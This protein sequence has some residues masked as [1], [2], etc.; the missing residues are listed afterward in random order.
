MRRRWQVARW[1]G[2]GAP[3]S[4]GRTLAATVV[5]AVSLVAC[6]ALAT[7]QQ[8]LTVGTL[9]A[10][11]G[12]SSSI[13][14][15]V[16]LFGSFGQPFAGYSQGPSVVW[17]GFAYAAFPP[18]PGI[19]R[20]IHLE[21]DPA[22]VVV[23]GSTSVTLR[24]EIRDL[25]DNVV[26]AASDLL[27]FTKDSGVG[28]L[29]TPNPVAAAN[30]RA[31]VT[32][33]SDTV[34]VATITCTGSGLL[35]GAVTVHFTGPAA[36]LWV[37]ADPRVLMADGKAKC[38][39]Q[40][41]VQDAN[42]YPVPGTPTS[43]TFATDVGT[44]VGPN[45][46]TTVDGVAT[47]ELQAASVEGTA[48]VTAT[49]DGLTAGTATVG[50]V[51]PVISIADTHRARP[52]RLVAIPLLVRG[53]LPIAG[54]QAT[55]EFDSTLL[56]FQRAS[57][58]ALIEGDPDWQ[59]VAHP[60]SPGKLVVLLT[61][62]LALKPLNVP[63][64][65]PL[66]NLLFRVSDMAANGTEAR[67]TF[68]DVT[69]LVDDRGDALPCTREDGL[70]TV[71][72]A[73]PE[74]KV[75]GCEATTSTVTVQFSGPADPADAGQ[76]NRYRI[77]C[78][79][80]TPVGGPAYVLYD[81]SSHRATLGGLALPSDQ[82]CKVIVLGIRDPLGN[83][84]PDDDV[85]NV[86]TDTVEGA[87]AQTTLSAGWN[88]VGMPLE[89]TNPSSAAVFG[90][91]LNPLPLVCYGW[92]GGSYQANPLWHAGGGGWLLVPPNG[93]SVNCAGTAPRL[94]Q[95]FALPLRT[96]WNIGSSPF[97]T[98]SVRLIDCRVRYKG[99]TRTLLDAPDWV[100]ALCYACD[101]PAGDYRL[102]QGAAA[103]LDPW[104]GNWLL[105]Q[106]DCDLLVP[107]V[108]PP[109]SRGA[110]FQPADNSAAV[111]KGRRS[112]TYA[113]GAGDWSITLAASCRQSRDT[114]TAAVSR[115]AT[116]GFDG[117][118]VDLPKPPP[119]PGNVQMVFHRPGWAKIGDL[120]LDA[121]ATDTRSSA[122]NRLVWDFDVH[123]TDQSATPN[124]K[125]EIPN[126]QSEI[127][128]TWPD[129]SAVPNRYHLAL[130]DTQTGSRR[131]LRT[132]SGYTFRL[133][134][135]ATC[136]F[137]LVADAGSSAALRVTGIAAAPSRGGAYVVSYQLSREA[138]VR[139]QL[140]TPTGRVVLTNA[141]PTRSRA[142]TNA[143]TLQPGNLPRGLYLLDLIASTEEGQA[144][145]GV[146]VVQLR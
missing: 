26:S 3:N 77:E 130:L 34:G 32:L 21:A 106:V 56:S 20:Q 133:P 42:G 22:S 76:T 52:G 17:G 65:E 98:H 144:A 12:E 27:T 108:P 19:P 44:L 87:S 90:D 16:K 38:L 39:V 120:A 25:H 18:P 72:A 102:E 10:G 88:L 24:A 13:D 117:F 111:R 40:A 68:T 82:D 59:V 94:D 30:G 8:R 141:A 119:S 100:A 73:A 36:K 131:Y 86:A 146:G 142:G 60:P 9:T 95:D 5:V 28:T 145:K 135:G 113:T 105:A 116:D 71:D 11:G 61:S 64:D 104:E 96:G 123:S 112:E 78:P 47:I 58:G 41:Q 45:P 83:A 15:Q 69:K 66:A 125:S 70:L 63:A 6:C 85:S 101:T 62:G 43:V 99:E 109:R 89:P 143:L 121:Y 50:F 124:L 103:I 107:P 140:R 84:I 48:T 1:L 57:K 51:I 75:T 29:G 93:A 54:V 139:L 128:L 79:P 81:Q 7:A 127:T 136:R 31:L 115:Q 67:F 110:G 53:P 122:A 134:A 97:T 91:D 33:T 35:N 49:A 37:D 132:L 137:Q 2:S 80:D 46:V 138:N 118:S 114:L 126:L 4:Y 74:L 14:N 55:V 129:L 23:S 92:S